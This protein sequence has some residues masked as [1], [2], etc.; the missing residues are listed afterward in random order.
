MRSVEIS[1]ASPWLMQQ[2]SCMLRRFHELVGFSDPIKQRKLADLCMATC[3][4]NV[5]GIPGSDVLALARR[6]TRLPTWHFGLEAV[7][8]TGTQQLSA[9]TAGTA[10]AAM[11]RILPGEAA[12]EYAS[13]P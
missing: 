6:L 10:V 2:L 12:A 9:A 7:Y 5:E 11:D 13:K 1:S 4:T 8:F 3:N